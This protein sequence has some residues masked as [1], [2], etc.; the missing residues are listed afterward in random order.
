MSPPVGGT[1][2]FQIFIQAWDGGS[3]LLPFGGVLSFRSAREV[4]GSETPRVHHAARRCGCVAA[5]SARTASGDACDRVPARRNTT[6]IRA[7][8]GRVSQ[9]PE[10]SGLFRG[11]ECND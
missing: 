11:A 4:L 7:N 6:R 3:S 8:D 2:W 1:F 9:E 5:R 10:R